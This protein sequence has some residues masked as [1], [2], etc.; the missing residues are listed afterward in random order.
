MKAVALTRYLPIANPESL[1]DVELE[2][3]VPGAS[4][5]LVRV[6][7]IA[8]NPVDVKVRAPKSKLEE[9]PRVLGWDAAG[10]VEA[11]GSAV[12]LFSPGDEV[13]YAG[14]ITRPGSNQQ[15]QAVDE[16]IVGRKPRSLDF[17]EAAAIP[18]TGITAYEAL[19][20]RLR[21]GHDG[22]SSG[23]SLLIIGGAGG[24]GSI[25]IQLAKLAGLRV[26]A[27]A[28]RDASRAWV[29]A[30]GADQVIDHTGNMKQQLDELGIGE[31]DA[32]AVFNDTSSHWASLPTLVK[33]QGQI[34]SI[35][36]TGVPLNLD[37]LKNKSLSFSWELMFTRAMYRTPDMIE[38]HRLLNRIADWVDA[39]K[40]RT[41]LS[42]RLSPINALNLRTAHEELET[43]R[44]VGKIVL[45]GWA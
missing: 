44:A 25:A 36:E 23:K 40:L 17:A 29:R 45:D 34:V 26:V 39:G 18:L 4:D 13:Y 10:V 1:L 35:V 2:R 20:E 15:W 11:V 27:T 21:F 30:L 7:A 28:S 37:I 19:F 3:P 32:V 12:T 5:L 9:K 33:P 43:G 24:V 6:Q 8:V 22:A 42:K 41:T 16:R 31:V 14:D 38:Q